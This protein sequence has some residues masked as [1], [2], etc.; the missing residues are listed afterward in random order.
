MEKRLRYLLQQYY[1]NK[2]S[3]KELTEFFDM[4]RT[5]RFDAQLAELLQEYYTDLK[6]QDPS[7]TFVD[8]EGRLSANAAEQAL[9][10][11][12]ATM[13]KKKSRK[14]PLMLAT[15]ALL[16]IVFTG[17]YLFL[18]PGSISNR[19]AQEHVIKESAQDEYKIISLSDGT[20]VWLNGSSRLEYP[21]EFSAGSDRE[22]RLIGEAYFEVSKAAD[23][24]FIVHTGEVQ[25]VV[26]G[27]EFNIKAYPGMQDVMVAVKSGKVRVR[28]EN[29]VLATLVKNEEFRIALEPNTLSGDERVLLDK[30]AGNWKEGY[31]EYEDETLASIVADIAR[32]YGI[33]IELKSESL[34]QKLVTT[35]MRKDIGPA[36]VL[37]IICTLTDIKM[38]H[39][40][41]KYILY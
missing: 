36:Q 6:R 15:A 37:H 30:T 33:Q 16:A 24:P 9:Q 4:V 1:T 21:Q 34:S 17:T 26:L 18:Q 29:K 23:W 40:N 12:A 35:A 28:K 19:M 22:V 38:T 11:Q 14:L 31:L 5:A 10:P 32:V 7:L 39:E 25:T 27:T 41:N 13:P 8:Q 20:K 2:A 3:H